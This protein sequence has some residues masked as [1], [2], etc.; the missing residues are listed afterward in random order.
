MIMKEVTLKILDL[1]YLVLGTLLFV[2]VNIGTFGYL[3]L[4]DEIDYRDF[5]PR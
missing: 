1:V 2:A 4:M 3:L 5:L